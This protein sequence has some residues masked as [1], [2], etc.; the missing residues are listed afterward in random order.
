[1]RGEIFKRGQVMNQWNLRKLVVTDRIESFRESKLT[2]QMN[3]I[4]E[5]WTRFEVHKDNLVVKIRH[6]KEKT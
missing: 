6:G 5:L 4:R 2:Y 3:N 1:M